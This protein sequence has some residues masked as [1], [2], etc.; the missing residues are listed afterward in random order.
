MAYIQKYPLTTVMKKAVKITII[1][2]K[3]TYHTVTRVCFARLK[4][5]FVIS[6]YALLTKSN[7]KA[8]TKACR[9]DAKITKI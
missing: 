3:F 4:A 5:S 6:I 9:P 8:K 2:I 7:M 1:N